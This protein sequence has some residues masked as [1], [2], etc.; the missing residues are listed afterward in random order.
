[1]GLP[2]LDGSSRARHKR[3]SKDY[4]TT[5]LIVAAGVVAAYLARDQR[6]P[7]SLMLGCL[8]VLVATCYWHR[9]NQAAVRLL[10]GVVPVVL[11]LGMALAQYKGTKAMAADV[12]AGA[13]TSTETMTAGAV[14]TVG[15]VGKWLLTLFFGNG[16]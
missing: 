6:G 1:M 14:T 4:R 8:S 10:V 15:D 13:S 12:T 11:M 3:S 2:M 9:A 5:A 16:S 7:V